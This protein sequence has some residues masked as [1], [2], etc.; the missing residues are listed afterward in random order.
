MGLD[1]LL[2]RTQPNYKIKSNSLIFV[3]VL[4]NC[5]FFLN[6]CQFKI[7][8]G[9]KIMNEV[10]LPRNLMR[11]VIAKSYFLRK[12]VYKYRTREAIEKFPFIL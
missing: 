1:V 7:F 6:N 8:E 3:R 2:L 12:Y 4:N 11:G 5:I 10:I 9:E